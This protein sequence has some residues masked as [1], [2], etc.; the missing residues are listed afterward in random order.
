MQEI[1]AKAKHSLKNAADHM[2]AQYDKKKQTVVDYHPGNKVWLNTTNLHL[3][4]PKKKLAD[5]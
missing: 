1:H 2:K 4:H 5:R 3:P